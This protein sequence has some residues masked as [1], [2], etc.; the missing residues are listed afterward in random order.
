MGPQGPLGP[1]LG[2][3]LA[4]VAVLVNLLVP[5]LQH[6]YPDLIEDSTA[7]TLDSLS[8]V[9]GIFGVGVVLGIFGVVLGMA[10]SLLGMVLDIL[11]MVLGILYVPI[12]GIMVCGRAAK[13]GIGVA[14]REIYDAMHA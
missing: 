3:T 14:A 2:I 11:G 10:Q 6:C 5:K 1:W 7:F 13:N 12:K 4:I 8:M 9:V